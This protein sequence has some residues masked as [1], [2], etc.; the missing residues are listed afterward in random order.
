MRR[1]EEYT[2][3]TNPPAFQI[4]TMNIF[5]VSGYDL[6]IYMNI[7]VFMFACCCTMLQIPEQ[8]QW[9]FACLYHPLLVNCSKTSTNAWWG[10]WGLRCCGRRQT[11][12]VP[13]KEK[14]QWHLVWDS[15]E[16]SNC[17]RNHFPSEQ[18]A[19]THALP[20]PVHI[21]F[22]LYAFDQIAKASDSGAQLRLR[23]ILYPP[24]SEQVQLVLE[25]DGRVVLKY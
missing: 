23:K 15:L 4:E 5:F 11:P 16:K 22:L 2:E 21:P 7:L 10:K 6:M 13:T 18:L 9:N 20:V 17:R 19:Y 25:C 14:K 24:H 8:G 3:Y 1:Y 12:V